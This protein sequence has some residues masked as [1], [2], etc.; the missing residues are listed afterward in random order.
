M[1]AL[2]GKKILLTGAT[3]FLGGLALKRLREVGCDVT[4]INRNTITDFTKG[5]ERETP[6]DTTS[7]QEIFESL[8]D[9]GDFSGSVLAHMAANIEG[10]E[11]TCN[12]ADLV[13]G[14]FSF[15]LNVIEAARK[16]GCT[17]VLNFGTVLQF[18]HMGQPRPVNLYAALK[19]SF[20]V[21]LDYYCDRYRMDAFSVILSDTYGERDCRSKIV[22]HII[23]CGLQKRICALSEGRQKI[24][25]IHH[26]DF[27]DALCFAL[28][29][30][31]E[32]EPRGL[33]HKY[34]LY[35]QNTVSIRDLAAKISTVTGLETKVRWGAIPA[36]DRLPEEPF[37]AMPPIAGWC[38]KVT[39][40]D[41]LRRTFLARSALIK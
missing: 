11:N 33:H 25:P 22:N 36:N 31:F 19:E 7:S 29:Q 40:E 28:I 35:G 39:L 37:G 5:T 10:Q 27:L 14:N 13:Q 6:C 30:I 3:G 15:A 9:L 32:K 23:D 41:G 2:N 34:S 26:D 4:C 21:I 16:K 17:R 8:S 24:R 20:Q 12:V 38:P 18:D 1:N